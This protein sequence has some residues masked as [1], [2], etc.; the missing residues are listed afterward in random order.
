LI[1]E[2]INSEKNE[3]DVIALEPAPYMLCLVA[4]DDVKSIKFI[5]Q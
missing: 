2:T 3:I 1:T 5:K 4:E